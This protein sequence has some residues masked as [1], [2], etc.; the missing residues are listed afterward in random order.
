MAGD[1]LAGKSA[2]VT[3]GA[4]GIGLATVTLLAE[5]GARVG[6]LGHDEAAVDHS[7][8]D[9]TAMG[10]DV[11]GL[12]ADVSNAADMQRAFSTFERSVGFLSILV[13]SAGIQ[14]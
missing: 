14:P 5:R 13:C 3:G 4:S 10:L 12:V 1:E 2:I 6:L 7:S 11:I 8:R 9:L